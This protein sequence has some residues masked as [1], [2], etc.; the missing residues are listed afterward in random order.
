MEKRLLRPALVTR[1]LVLA[2]ALLSGGIVLIALGAPPPAISG[3]ECFNR[4][5]TITSN[6][7]FVPGTE[8][9][10][11]IVTG[12]ADNGVVADTGNDRVCTNGGK[13]FVRGD[14]GDDRID[15][16][17]GKDKASGGDLNPDNPSGNDII[18]G[19][20]GD[21]ELNGHDG[22]DVLNGGPGTDICRGGPGADDI[23]NCEN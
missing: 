7:E 18:K 20:R 8:G 14:L 12:G 23:R 16:G 22:A 13:D 4:A 15:L 17:R 6:D 1:V 5:A 11:V 3:S 9:A 10:D 21:D 19:G 2:G